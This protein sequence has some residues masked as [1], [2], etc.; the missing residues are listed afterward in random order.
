MAMAHPLFSQSTEYKSIWFTNAYPSPS[1]GTTY[2]NVGY[3][4]IEIK[5]GDRF[6]LE[7]WGHHAGRVVYSAVRLPDPTN[8]EQVYRQMNDSITW[9]NAINLNTGGTVAGPAFVRAFQ[10]TDINTP[11][12]SPIWTYATV[13]QYKLQR[14]EN[15]ETNTSANI[16]PS[17]AVVVPSNATGDVDVLL[18]QSTDMITWTQ[19]LPGTYN[20]STQKRFFRVRAV[21]K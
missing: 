3:Q 1:G 14:T 12:Y 17:A 4:D 8:G 10:R 16:I 19:C 20:A 6:T 15:S 2:N 7:G 11:G 21:E 9:Y 13:L 5:S 18:E